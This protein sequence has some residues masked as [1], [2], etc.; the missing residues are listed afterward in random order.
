MKEALIYTVTNETLATPI[1]LVNEVLRAAWPLTLPRAPFGCLGLLDVRGQ[2]IPFMD[3]AVVLGL[4]APLRIQ[5]LADRLLNSHVLRVSA[6]GVEIGFLVD[7]VTEVGEEGGE[8]TEAERVTATT[9]GR[10]AALVRGVAIASGRRVL[11]LDL[12]KALG[13]GRSDLLRRRAAA[14]PES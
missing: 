5:A 6:S 9:L 1:A 12:S 13:V 3:L 10:A 14:S 11:M 7:R 8:L 4:R 2:L